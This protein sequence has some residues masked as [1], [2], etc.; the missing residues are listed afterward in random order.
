MIREVTMAT[1]RVSNP[2]FITKPEYLKALRGMQAANLAGLVL[3]GQATISWETLNVLTDDDAEAAHLHFRTLFD[4]WLHKRQLPKAYIW[5]VERGPHLGIHSHFAFSMPK[6][7]SPPFRQWFRSVTPTLTG[8]EPVR[9][10]SERGYVETLHSE[11]RRDDDVS[12]QLRTFRYFMKGLEPNAG[13]AGAH[14]LK[15]QPQGRIMFK[16]IGLSRSID[17]SAA[18]RVAAS[19]GGWAAIEQSCAPVSD[20]HYRL[21]KSRHGNEMDP[22][23]ER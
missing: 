15:L 13:L 1:K 17:R 19:Y 4:H 22:T 8:K 2:D 7:Y 11:V 12:A 5:V 20:D 3:N 10:V 9:E 6:S 16:R 21:W 23:L 18:D 14:G